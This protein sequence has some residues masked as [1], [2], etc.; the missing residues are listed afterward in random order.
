MTIRWRLGLL[1][2]QLIVLIVL[3]KVVSGHWVLGHPWFLAGLLGVVV[4]P[5]LL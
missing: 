3:A 5:Q 2:V 1:V 4:N